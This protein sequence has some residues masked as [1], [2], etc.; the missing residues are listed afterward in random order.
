MERFH[1]NLYGK[2]G[3]M[4]EGIGIFVDRKNYLFFESIKVDYPNNF[5]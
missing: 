4:K 5:H 1:S 2:Y 3:K